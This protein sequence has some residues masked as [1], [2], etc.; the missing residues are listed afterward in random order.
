MTSE[1]W[2][3]IEDLCHAAL[4]RPAEAFPP[5]HTSEPA[6]AIGEEVLKGRSIL[7]LYPATEE[8]T[9]KD[10]EAWRKANKR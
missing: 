9:R 4:A 3:Q 10:F 1:R 5:V 8:Q 6:L 7:G 2:R